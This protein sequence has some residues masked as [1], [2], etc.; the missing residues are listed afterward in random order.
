VER[1]REAATLAMTPFDPLP[2]NVA[3]TL[4][5]EGDALLRFLED[6]AVTFDVRQNPPL[7]AG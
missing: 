6:D 1:K 3:A 2:K 4:A 7:N 5:E